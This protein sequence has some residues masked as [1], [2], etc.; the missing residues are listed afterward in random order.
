MGFFDKT[1]K[2]LDMMGQMFSRTGALDN[3]ENFGMRQEAALKAAMIACNR[4][5]SV[6]ACTK[7]LDQP[8]TSQKTPEFCPNAKRIADLKTTI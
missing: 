3:C 4:C 7:W 6:E 2:R 1:A 5:D 8:A